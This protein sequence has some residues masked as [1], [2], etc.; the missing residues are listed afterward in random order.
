MRITEVID[1]TRLD[2]D[3]VEKHGIR[4]VITFARTQTTIEDTFSAAIH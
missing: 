3:L 2:A 1:P 4:F